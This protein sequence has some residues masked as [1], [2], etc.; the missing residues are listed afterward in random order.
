LAWHELLK[1]ESLGRKPSQAGHRRLASQELPSDGGKKSRLVVGS[2][3]VK[4]ED[5]VRSQA[6]VGLRKVFG[7]TVVPRS[8]D[9]LDALQLVL[10]P[11]KTSIIVMRTA[12]GKSALFLVPAALAEQKTVIVIVP[13]T[14]LADDLLDNAVKAGIDY[15][16]WSRDY[17]DGELHALVV[18]SADVAVD[19]DFLYYAQGLQL[20]S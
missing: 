1:L 6:E 8:S 3:R 16:R 10:N 15:R 20:S 4:T 18:V 11:L 13:Y 19:E 17:A 14:A 9:Q 12:G 7:P 5:E 2:T